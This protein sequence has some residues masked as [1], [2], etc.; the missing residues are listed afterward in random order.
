MNKEYNI[1]IRYSETL[2]EW[3]IDSENVR[4]RYKPYKKNSVEEVFK[5]L[6]KEQLK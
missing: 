1:I 6:F 4:L 5:I 3:V 2:Q